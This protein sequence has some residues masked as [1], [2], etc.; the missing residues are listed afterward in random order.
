MVP[1]GSGLHELQVDS[2]GA[3]REAIGMDP[4]AVSLM[5]NGKRRMS[6]KEAAD[7]ACLL[8]VPVGEVLRHAGA[9]VPANRARNVPVVGRVGQG[10]EITFG[11]AIGPR[12][13]IAPTDCPQD[14]Q[15]LR[16]Q[17]GTALDG[18]LLFYQPMECVSLEAVG[19]LCVVKTAEGNDLV[20]VVNRGYGPGFFVLT[21]LLGGETQHVRLRSAAPV[22]WMRQ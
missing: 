1:T 13:A 5:L 9:P 12:T 3:Q 6:A 14:C 19:R 20:R 15:A 17:S 8:G 7:V 21:R 11:A 22:M 16:C 18:W 2:A 4:S 10:G